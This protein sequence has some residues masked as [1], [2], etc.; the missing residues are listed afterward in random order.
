[1]HPLDPLGRILMVA[2][3]AL[4][5]IGALIAWGPRLRWLGRLPGDFTFRIGDATIYVPLGTCLLVSL[6]LTLAAW[7]LRRR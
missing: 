7:I 5:A 6:V 1:M 2:G 3:V 4:L